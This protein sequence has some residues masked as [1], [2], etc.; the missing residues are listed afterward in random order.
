MR[1]EPPS[2]P[3]SD[4]CALVPANAVG[5]IPGTP[6]RPVSTPASQDGATQTGQRKGM[7][8]RATAETPR[9]G[10]WSAPDTLALVRAKREEA[11]EL[12]SLPVNARNKPASE[13]WASIVAKLRSWGVDRDLKMCT[14]RWENLCRL[15][16]KVLEH[17]RSPGK[18][19]FWNLTPAERKGAH[20]NFNLERQVYDEMAKFVGPRESLTPMRMLDLPNLDGNAQYGNSNGEGGGDSDGGESEPEHG[21][22]DAGDRMTDQN[23][24]AGTSSAGKRRRPQA[25]HRGENEARDHRHRK[26]MAAVI[27]KLTDT[28]RT[29]GEAFATAFAV[30]SGRQADLISETH[31]IMREQT[32]VMREANAVMDSGNKALCQALEGLSSAL[33][34]IA[35]S[36]ATPSNLDWRP[37]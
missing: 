33:N 15:Y 16:R 36:L 21:E 27:A 35:R 14:R 31:L 3:V 8:R 9:S 29:R 5:S 26:S 2:S 30:A 28:V 20:V 1:Q 25:N 12:A 11:E 7:K 18:P 17:E 19:S 37:N 34:S 10:N 23:G 32:Q 4:D 6:E 22:S 24:S 13:K